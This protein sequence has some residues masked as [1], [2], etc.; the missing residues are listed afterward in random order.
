[1]T[2]KVPLSPLERLKAEPA[3]FSLDQAAIVLGGDPLDLRYRSQARLGAPGGEVASANPETREV[4][5]PT[6]GLIGPGGV[7]P[8]HYTATVG[9][10]A[11]KRSTALHQFMDMLARRFTG[12][13]VKAGAKYRPARDPKPAETVLAAAA[14]LGTPHLVARLA[15][16]LPA[17]LYHAGALASR[18][19]SAERLRGLLT[20]E[21]GTPVEI[22]EFAGGWIRLPAGEQSRM[23]GRGRP[24]VNCGLGTDAALGAQAWDPSARFLLRLGP[25]KLR[26]FEALLPGSPLH[27][28]LVELVRLQIGLEQDFALNPVLAADEV[29]PLRLGGPGGGARLGW[30]GWL[31]TPRPR[32]ADVKDALLR[33][34][35]PQTPPQRMDAA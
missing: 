23:A 32:R 4:V 13:F 21:T 20:E 17:L 30:T 19:R 29:P 2:A 31:T 18:S 12:L 34:A 25:L 7:L 8:R 33:P 3:R 26:E 16:P 24:G 1:M 10:E 22:V 14:G 5:T 35:A 27:G 15:T 28:R 11:R 6:F 9:A